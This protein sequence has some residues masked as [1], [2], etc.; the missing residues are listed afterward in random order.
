MLPTVAFDVTPYPFAEAAQKSCLKYWPERYCYAH[1][2][3]RLTR[4]TGHVVN[5][6]TKLPKISS[7]TICAGSVRVP[8]RVRA[9]LEPTVSRQDELRELRGHTLSFV[10][11]SKIAGAAAI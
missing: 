10:L 5:L 9:A 3:S 2:A 4:G 8:V 1:R 11:R 7:F 6:K